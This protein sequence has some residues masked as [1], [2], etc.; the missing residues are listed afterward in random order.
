MR[1]LWITSL[2]VLFGLI[3]G[4]ATTAPVETSVTPVDVSGTWQG[5]SDARSIFSPVRELT[6]VLQ[7]SGTKVTGKASLGGDLEGVVSSN[8]FSYTLTSSDGGGD[9]TVNG[10]AMRGYGRTGAVLTLKRAR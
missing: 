1:S 10:D 6:L 3:S 9:L 8:R 5:T 2:V 7:Q 4:C